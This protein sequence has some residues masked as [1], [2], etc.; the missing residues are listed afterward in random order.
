MEAYRAGT[1]F[2]FTSR[3]SRKQSKKYFAVRYAQRTRAM[4]KKERSRHR[5]PSVL[6]PR[7]RRATEASPC[8]ARRR[9][10]QKDEE[11]VR[12]EYLRVQEE[13][14]ELSTL[15]EPKE[16]GRPRYLVPKARGGSP[17]PRRRRSEGDAPWISRKVVV[18]KPA[19]QGKDS[20]SDSSS[21]QPLPPGLVKRTR[22][23]SFPRQSSPSSSR[24]AYQRSSGSA[25][26]Y[27]DKSPRP[28]RRPGDAPRRMAPPPPLPSGRIMKP[29][30]Q[31]DWRHEAEELVESRRSA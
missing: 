6:P 17:F 28:S 3:K 25:A 5:S 7:S 4:E 24:G 15:N 19:S 1:L 12:D 13:R 26:Y 10:T 20:Q 8:V 23:T 14:Q 21:L 31:G 11:E 9:G 2:P 30:E 22:S 18:L 29:W 16:R 27:P